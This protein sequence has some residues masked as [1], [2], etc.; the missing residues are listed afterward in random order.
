MIIVTVDHN[1]Y[2]TL[3]HLLENHED[4]RKANILLHCPRSKN[5]K[6]ASLEKGE[7]CSHNSWLRVLLPYLDRNLGYSRGS[8]S[9][10]VSVSFHSPFSRNDRSP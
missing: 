1:K 5:K 10:F 9:L 6:E 3:G 4:Q 2:E 8:S 7:R